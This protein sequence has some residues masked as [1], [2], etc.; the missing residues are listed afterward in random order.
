[1][2]EKRKNPRKIADEVLEVSDQHTNTRLGRVV[3][4][5]AEGLMLISSESFAQGSVYALD[6]LL[7]RLIKNH[8]KISFGA[9]VVWSTPATQPGSHWTGF[10][11]I[12]ASED[13]VLTIDELIL[14]W[15]TAD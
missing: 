10:H 7:P 8:S 9:E 2:S 4:I 5:S 1:M 14:D 3:N 12:D 11:I 15:H 6:L 13:D